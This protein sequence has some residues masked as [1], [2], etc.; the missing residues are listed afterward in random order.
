METVGFLAVYVKHGN[1]GEVGTEGGEAKDEHRSGVGGV[2][3]VGLAYKHRNDSTS[4][5]LDEEDHG[6]GS[7]ETLQGDDLRHTGPEG[8]GHRA[9]Q[10][11]RHGV[12]R[13][14]PAYSD[15][16]PLVVRVRLK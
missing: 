15:H 2:G 12:V 3:L 6:V 1:G 8:G 11:D 14:Q 7:A 16:L 4:E 13:Y 9:S 5:V 10:G